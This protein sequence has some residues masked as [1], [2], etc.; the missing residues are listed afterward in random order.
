MGGYHSAS[1]VTI[2]FFTRKLQQTL[3]TTIK[4]KHMPFLHY[5]IME[6]LLAGLLAK[7]TPNVE[8]EDKNVPRLSDKEIKFEDVAYAEAQK[9]KVHIKACFER[10]FQSFYFFSQNIL[11][12]TSCKKSASYFQIASTIF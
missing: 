9:G 4:T 5:L 8:E 1:N 6:M 11:Y 3:E 7:D 10:I 2:A 12:S